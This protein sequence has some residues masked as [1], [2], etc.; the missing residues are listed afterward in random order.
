MERRPRRCRTAPCMRIATERQRRARSL[1]QGLAIG[2]RSRCIRETDKT[3]PGACVAGCSSGYRS[4]RRATTMIGV[5][6]AH[7]PAHRL[8]T[9]R[10]GPGFIFYANEL[11][12]SY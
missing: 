6:A 10:A 3:R 5:V 1:S 2:K 11:A 8:E 7:R 12:G 9:F 4:T